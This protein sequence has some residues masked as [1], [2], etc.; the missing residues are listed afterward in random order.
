METSKDF[1]EFVSK[2]VK[3]IGTEA[4]LKG[5]D[6]SL[7]DFM[8]RHFNDHAI[9]E[10]VYKSVRYATQKQEEDI[11]KIAAWAYIIWKR[12]FCCGELIP[13]TESELEEERL[14]SYEKYKLKVPQQ[15]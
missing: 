5:Y 15:P 2:M 7:T 11:L 1:N 12:D 9:G 6:D 14:K 4:G 8:K 3:K 10:I 13:K